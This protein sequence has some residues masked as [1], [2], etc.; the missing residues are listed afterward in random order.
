MDQQ[1]T[2]RNETYLHPFNLVLDNVPV[3]SWPGLAC[4]VLKPELMLIRRALEARSKIVLVCWVTLETLWGRLMAR[5]E[6]FPVTQ[7]MIDIP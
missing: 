7:S 1:L 4:S 3:L 6:P 5:H 2:N